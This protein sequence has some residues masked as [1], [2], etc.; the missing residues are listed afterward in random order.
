[1]IDNRKLSDPEQAMEILNRIANASNVV[2]SGRIL[3][4]L[5]EEIVRQA[6][7]LIQE[8]HPR[9]NSRI[10]GDLDNLRF[11]T[12][13]KKI[14]LR[15]VDKHHEEQWQEIVLKELN[16]QIESSEV[17]LRAILIQDQEL[18]KNSASHLIITT[19]HAI[20]DGL[21]STHLY[22]EFLSYCSKVASGEPLVPVSSL[23][24]LPSVDELL[25][26]ST[27]G[28][29]GKINTLLYLLQLQLKLLWHRPETLEK[30]KSVPLDSLTSGNIYRSL[31][32]D[33]TEQL[34]NRCR[35][36]K[37]TV[38][39]ALCAAMMFAAA[40][41]IRPQQKTRVSCRSIVN[42]RK[43]LKQVVGNEN[44]GI[45]ASGVDSF[46][47][48]ETNT[49]FWELARDVIQQLKVGLKGDSIFIDMLL[50]RKFIEILM[51]RPSQANLTVA[52]SNIG[53]V[54]IPKVYGQFELSEISFVASQ[55]TLRGC[56]FAAVVTFEG[57][58]FL[59]FPFAMPSVSQET[60]ETVVDSALSYLDDASKGRSTVLK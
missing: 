58:M 11:E 15:V 44:M 9:L 25:P 51:S 36:E 59:H 28:F 12:G 22:S 2:V 35:Q 23:S 38:Q 30:N 60:M 10:V 56:F 31:D 40:R 46:H 6:L 34:V 8:R 27:R 45:M 54:N 57:K 53:R 21:S 19:N 16:T 14:P 1:M 33:F 20:S 41:K 3:G 32:A 7:D 55:P 18:G 47:T 49:S 43:Y 29:R 4:P 52:V 39:G 17:L 48:L 42:I 50:S 5:S 13:A 26:P 24:A 37:T